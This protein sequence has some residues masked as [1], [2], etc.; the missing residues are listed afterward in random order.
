MKKE[1]RLMWVVLIA[2]PV[3][4]VLVAIALAAWIVTGFP[5]A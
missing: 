4:I 3:L 2:Y 1:T 5:G